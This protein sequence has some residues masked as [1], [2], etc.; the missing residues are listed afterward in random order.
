[1]QLIAKL[2]LELRLPKYGDYRF[3]SLLH[4]QVTT[5]NV[6]LALNIQDK[7]LT[8]ILSSFLK[9]LC[10]LPCKNRNKGGPGQGNQ[11]VGHIM[12]SRGQRNLLLCW[13]SDPTPS[14]LTLGALIIMREACNLITVC[15]RGSLL[16]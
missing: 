12:V 15:F 11:K 9:L 7:Q 6:M 3:Q 10:K 13:P 5:T 4:T 16:S 2:S 1:V 8:L 14:D